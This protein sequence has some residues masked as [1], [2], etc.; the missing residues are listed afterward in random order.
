MRNSW[1]WAFCWIAFFCHPLE[2]TTIL[3]ERLG[4][5]KAGDYIV[6]ESNKMISVLAIRSLT[7]KSLILEE[8]GVPA[9]AVNPRPASWPK[10]VHDLAP[11]HT[12]WSMLEIDYENHEL[13]ECYS[14]SRSAW[15]ELSSQESFISTILALSLQPVPVE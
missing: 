1:F 12:S 4:K 9:H 10:W 2:A 14:F 7:P 11:G 6:T 13:I 5:A 3:Q 8:I 15:V